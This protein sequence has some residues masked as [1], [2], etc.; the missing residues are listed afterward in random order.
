M[1][2]IDTYSASPKPDSKEEIKEGNMEIGYVLPYPGRVLPDSPIWFMKALRDKVW[3][4]STTNIMRKA[5][6]S[7]LFA[8]KRLSASYELFKNE[9]PLLA[10]T[11]LTKAEKY[12][13]SA[14]AIEKKERGKGE[15]TKSFL[16]TL[17]K[18]SLKHREVIE[19]MLTIVPDDIKPEVIKAGDYPKNVYKEC[20]DALQSQ[21][22]SAPENP[23]D[24]N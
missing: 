16:L 3:M 21:G 5:E 15:D 13:E 11:T 2:A 8:D 10:L 12:L 17:A 6:L 9:K 23:F 1:N 14:S 7:L 18:A 20:R 22:V 19:N 4:G 24:T